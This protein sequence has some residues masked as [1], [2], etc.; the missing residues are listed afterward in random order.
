L[1][2]K[3]LQQVLRLGNY[4]QLGSAPLLD[5]LVASNNYSQME[6]VVRQQQSLFCRW[7]MHISGRQA[8]YANRRMQQGQSSAEGSLLQRSS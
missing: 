3:F 6:E 4:S 8:G 5:P 7:V 2:A 1:S